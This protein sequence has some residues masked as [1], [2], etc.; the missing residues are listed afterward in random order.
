MNDTRKKIL[1][2]II[3]LIAIALFSY[4]LWRMFRNNQGISQPESTKATSSEPG[5]LRPSETIQPRPIVKPGTGDGLEPGAESVTKDPAASDSTTRSNK[6]SSPSTFPIVDATISADGNSVQYYDPQDKKFY[7]TDDNGAPEAIS[8]QAFYNVEKVVWSPDK[9]R[10]ILE[11][12]DDTKIIYNFQN[13]T[14]ISLPKHWQDF[15]FSP[16]GDQIAF[17]SIGFE[18][19]NR[20]LSVMNADGT[21]AQN[22]EK[23]G[24]N[25]DKAN[26]A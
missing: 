15:Q 10:A 23:L 19:E 8:D 13:R 22:I 11:Y 16:S 25:A 6:I 21:Q 2:L 3:F 5:R 20:W 26:V 17:K 4:L 14:Q 1:A 24:A 12:P 18:P 7:R 9:S